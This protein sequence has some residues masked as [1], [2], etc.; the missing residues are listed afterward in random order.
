MLEDEEM[1]EVKVKVKFFLEFAVKN[2][3]RLHLYYIELMYAESKGRLVV[4]HKQ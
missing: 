1:V 3:R 2:V 4:K